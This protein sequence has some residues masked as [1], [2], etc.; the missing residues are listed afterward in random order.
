MEQ[1]FPLMTSPLGAATQILDITYLGKKQA[2]VL[3]P[4]GKVPYL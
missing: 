1:E 2:E 4:H 3:T